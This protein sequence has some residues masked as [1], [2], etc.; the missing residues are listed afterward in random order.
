MEEVSFMTQTLSVLVLLIICSFT[1]IL[2]K[3]IN[4]PYTVLLVL[5]GLILIPIS[6]IDFFSFIDDF[7]LTP[8]LLFFVFLPLLLFEAAYNINYRQ[9]FNNWKT[10]AL[11]AIFWLLISWWVIAGVL[12]FALPYVWF[13]VPFLVCL[14]FWILISSTD[15]VAVLSIFKSL[16]AP[17]RLIILFEWES[18]F[19]DGTAVAMFLVI[20]WV[21]LEWW[22]VTSWVYIEWTFKFLS[23][24]FGGILFGSFTGVLFSKIIWRINNNEEVEIVLTLL[25]AHITFILAQLISTY[26]PFFPISWVIATVVASIVIWNYWRYKITPKVEAHMQKFWELFA[27]ISNSLIFILMGLIL[28]TINIELKQFILP[29]IISILTVMIARVISVFIPISIVNWFKLEEKIPKSWIILLSW[30]SLRWV[31]ALMMILII[32]WVWDVW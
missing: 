28:S 15:P 12:Y 5:V 26:F 29:I 8:D 4:F 30:W 31:L 16:W 13:N 17:R 19:N 7:K 23:M 1:Y 24:L 25:L 32:P 6:Y 27:F 9:L 3:K 14:M 2:S 22:I 11:L 10:I 18:L 21:I 20:L